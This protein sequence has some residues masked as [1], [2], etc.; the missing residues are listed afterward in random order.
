MNE[1]K[2]KRQYLRVENKKWPVRLAQVPADRLPPIF[3]AN[4]NDAPSFV[5]RSRDFVVQLFADPSGKLRL[6]VNR[7]ELDSTGRWKDGIT[8]DD[9]QR[10]KG[11]AGFG[12]LQAVE[13]YPPD[14]DVVN[15]SNMRHLWL[16][17]EPLPFAWKNDVPEVRT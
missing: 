6:S 12:Q 4:P 5:W 7:T 2:Q 10:L 9:L 16:M 8:W 1:L 13:I 14:G 15:V 3:R 17:A 11:E